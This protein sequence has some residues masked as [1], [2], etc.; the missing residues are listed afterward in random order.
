MQMIFSRARAH[1]HAHAH[2]QIIF[3][4]MPSW[5]AS[6]SPQADERLI[7]CPTR[8]PRLR[9]GGGGDDADAK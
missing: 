7:Q 4:L 3:D 6:Q 5:I 1:A 2:A 9:F 8:V